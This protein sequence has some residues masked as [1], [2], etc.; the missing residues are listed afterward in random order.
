M[1]ARAIVERGVDSAAAVSAGDRSDVT[2]GCRFSKV[3]GFFP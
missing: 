2:Q 1:N 3:D